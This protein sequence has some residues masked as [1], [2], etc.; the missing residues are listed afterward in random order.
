MSERCQELE[1]ENKNLLEALALAARWIDAH[2]WVENNSPKPSLKNKGA[3]AFIEVMEV[4][5]RAQNK[6]N[7]PPKEK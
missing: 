3:K 2:Y 5:K 7:P 1:N 4:I 6:K